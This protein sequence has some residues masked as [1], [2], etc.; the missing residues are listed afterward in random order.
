MSKEPRIKFSDRDKLPIELL[1]RLAYRT[2]RMRIQKKVRADVLKNKFKLSKT[3]RGGM[4]VTFKEQPNI[5]DAYK[6]R[7]IDEEVSSK[8]LSEAEHLM[9]LWI[10]LLRFLKAEDK[11]VMRKITDLFTI[12][13]LPLPPEMLVAA[14]IPAN[15]SFMNDKDVDYVL[16]ELAAK[17]LIDDALVHVRTLLKLK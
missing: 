14:W 3:V 10:G 4:V 9:Y 12:G 2:V 17:P 15:I 11:L 6:E 13:N 16:S 1:A 7:N 8:C 5:F